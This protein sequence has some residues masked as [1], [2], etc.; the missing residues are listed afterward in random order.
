MTQPALI[1]T[2]EAAALL[3]LKNV[4]TV[5]RMVKEG[6]LAAAMKMPGLTGALLFRREDIEELAAAKAEAS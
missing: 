6:R 4:S 3:G 5:T 2:R 1:S